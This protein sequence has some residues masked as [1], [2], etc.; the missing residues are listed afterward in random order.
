MVRHPD[1]SSTCAKLNRAAEHRA[2]LERLIS[3]HFA[4]E[5]NRATGIARYED[6]AGCHVIRIT[7]IPASLRELLMSVSLAVGDIAHNL[8]SALDHTTCQPRAC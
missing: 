2:A 1:F 3:D 6:A 7:H 4:T 8:R 5:A